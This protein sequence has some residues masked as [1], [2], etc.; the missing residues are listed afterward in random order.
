MMTEAPSAAP[1]WLDKPPTSF[2]HSPIHPGSFGK[3]LRF[4]WRPRPRAARG[5]RDPSNLIQTMLA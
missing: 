1:A 2:E 5:A 3:K 4:R